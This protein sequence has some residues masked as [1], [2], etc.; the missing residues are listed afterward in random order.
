MVMHLIA[1]LRSDA[2][3]ARG[4]SAENMIEISETKTIMNVQLPFHLDFQRR[5]EQKSLNQPL[6]LGG[7]GEA[8][9]EILA[10]KAINL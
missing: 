3:C 2:M 8:S 5:Y 6:S 1:H 9:T 10:T 4:K 7:D